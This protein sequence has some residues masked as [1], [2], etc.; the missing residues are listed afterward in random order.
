MR[1]QILFALWG[2]LGLVLPARAQ[3][4]GYTAPQTTQQTLATS[5]A[6]TGSQQIYPVSN[7]GQTQHY[8]SVG[9][10]LNI[11]KFQAEIDGVDTSGNIY[12]ISDVLEING[13]SFVT[14]HQGTVSAAG[15][16]PKVQISVT[17]T[18]SGGPSSY[19]LSYSGAWGTFNVNTGSYLIGQIDKVNFFGADATVMQTDSFQTPF[20]SSAGTI[21]V[22]FS[23]AA[24]TSTLTVTCNLNGIATATSVFTTALASSTSV[25]SFSVPDNACPFANVVYSGGPASGL[26]NV[27]YVFSLPGRNNG[28]STIGSVTQ[29]TIPWVVSGTVTSNPSLSA[30]VI[31]GQQSVTN[32]ATA[33]A[34]NALAHGIC[35][36]AL[37][38]NA[39]S[40]FIGPTGVTITTGL[41]LP[42]KSS[43]CLS[44]SNSNAVFVVDAAGG[45]NVTWVGN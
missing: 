29:G 25:Q 34:S 27:E 38:T 16:F 21:Y 23:A 18:S 31:S 36:Q 17:C 44:V 10:V 45:D 13:L 19:T 5:Q 2:L 12:R 28:G 14:N 42:A 26:V 7:L 9:N 4:I 1:K 8:I 20:G 41:E 3:F 33:L 24:G 15:Y 37:S 32:S 22:Q 43:T 6:C 40:V 35:V 30:T 11:A 39:A